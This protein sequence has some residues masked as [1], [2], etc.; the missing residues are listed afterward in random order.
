MTKIKITTKTCPLC[1]YIYKRIQKYEIVEKQIAHMFS[2]N[3]AFDNLKESISDK[4]DKLVEECKEDTVTKGDQDFEY[5]YHKGNPM[6]EY[7]GGE[8]EKIYSDCI[9]MFCP[10]CGIFLNDNICTKYVEKEI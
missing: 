7:Y 1:G 9:G 4:K 10:K 8:P 3:L 5:V 2:F 6:N